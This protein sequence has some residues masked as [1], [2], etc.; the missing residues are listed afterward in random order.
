MHPGIIHSN[1]GLTLETSVFNFSS[2]LTPLT[3]MSSFFTSA[4]CCHPLKVGK[5][6]IISTYR[7]MIFE[8]RFVNKVYELDPSTKVTGVPW[9]PRGYVSKRKMKG[10]IA[11]EGKSK[12]ICTPI[13][14]KE[15]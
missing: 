15:V 7:A 10:S 11:N 3:L 1:E 12:K 2:A 8:N 4:C 5:K 13:L 6:D 14:D 9:Q